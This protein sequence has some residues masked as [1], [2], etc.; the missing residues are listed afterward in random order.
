MGYTNLGVVC[1]IQQKY[2]QSLDYHQK[3]FRIRQKHLPPDHFRFGTSYN[4]MGEV[5]HD[6]DEYDLALKYYDMALEVY[7]KSLPSRHVDIAIVLANKGDIYEKKGDLHEALVLYKKALS[8]CRYI[9]PTKNS[10]LLQIEH[11]MG[12]AEN[13]KETNLDPLPF[14]TI[15]IRLFRS[16]KCIASHD[17]RSAYRE[18]LEKKQ[19]TL[20]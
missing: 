1:R 20:N 19:S 4:N 3:A 15:W 14:R 18:S 16:F 5:Y 7:S 13:A 10:Q 17:P 9:W 12:K 6:R 11:M 2:S 8:I